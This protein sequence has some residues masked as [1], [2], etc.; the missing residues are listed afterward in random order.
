MEQW[1]MLIISIWC[2]QTKKVQSN[3]CWGCSSTDTTPVSQ[4][5]SNVFHLAPPQKTLS[6]PSAVIMTDVE[7][8]LRECFRLISLST[9]FGF[10][11]LLEIN[12][13]H[14]FH[15]VPVWSDVGGVAGTN[16]LQH[17]SAV[18]RC[19]AKG[20]FDLEFV[21]AVNQTMVRSTSW[22]TAKSQRV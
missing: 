22:A 13:P 8:Y 16:F 6:P 7:S 12:S 15:I 19:L 10:N 11:R 5:L 2:C 20:P 4:Y 9:T 21:G 3:M 14:L 1:S 18:V 17:K